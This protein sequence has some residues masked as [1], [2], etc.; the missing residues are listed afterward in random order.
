MF[1][2]IRY[3]FIK[4]FSMRLLL[5]SLVFILLAGASSCTDSLD[6]PEEMDDC[7]WNDCPDDEQDTMDTEYE[8]YVLWSKDMG[9]NFFGLSPI[10]TRDGSI[11]YSSNAGSNHIAKVSAVTGH[12]F[13]RWDYSFFF[14]EEVYVSPSADHVFVSKGRRIVVVDDFVGEW[15]NLIEEK[16]FE[17]LEEGYLG[18]DYF[19]RAAYTG[20][21]GPIWNV[22]RAPINNFE[23]SEVL[24]SIN[25]ED[26]GAGRLIIGEM[27]EWLN[28]NTGERHLFVESWLN[29]NEIL[30]INYNISQRRIEWDLLNF[31]NNPNNNF[32]PNIREMRIVNDKILIV[33]NGD[34]IAV[35]PVTGSIDWTYYSEGAGPDSRSISSPVYIP[36]TNELLTVSSGYNLESQRVSIDLSSGQVSRNSLSNPTTFRNPIYYKDHIL[37]FSQAETET[38]REKHI[39]EVWNASNLSLEDRIEIPRFRK[40]TLVPERDC[41]ILVSVN[42]LFSFDLEQIISL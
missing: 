37:T 17:V 24:F 15:R 2:Y 32:N 3:Y 20:F 19:Y 5:Y 10:E 9:E 13:W 14:A 21:Y 12:E 30:L 27:A 29:N 7:R 6:L 38:G 41:F 33:T 23:P 34:I 1:Y 36:T 26:Y 18:K 39:L 4:L 16:D 40:A 11:Y 28:P 31:I 22:L 35:N 8:N 25:A 42:E